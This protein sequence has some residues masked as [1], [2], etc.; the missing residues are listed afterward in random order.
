MRL[1]AIR[2]IMGANGR[3]AMHRQ[4]TYT[5]EYPADVAARLKVDADADG[6]KLS[7]LN[8]DE[9]RAA[10]E[11]LIIHRVVG[12]DA[13][14]GYIVRGDNKNAPDPDRPTPA[15][16]VGRAIVVIPGLGW[17]LHAIR[18]PLVLA[19]LAA[20]VTLGLVWDEL[21]KR[22]ARAAGGDR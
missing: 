7:I 21:R 12:G 5:N 1:G 19:A 2:R 8:P 22:E 18:Y 20:I 17:V 4:S 9:A 16:I 6:H 15:A 3:V 14:S 10:P 13:T 11:G